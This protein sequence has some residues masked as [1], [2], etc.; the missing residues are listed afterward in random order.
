[1]YIYLFLRQ[2]NK[3]KNKE[4]VIFEFIRHTAEKVLP[5]QL[6]SKPYPNYDMNYIVYIYSFVY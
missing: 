5:I 3:T 6:M 1:M 4:K 2:K